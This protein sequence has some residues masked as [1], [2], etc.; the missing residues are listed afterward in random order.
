MK[1]MGIIGGLGPM[2]TAH[3]L[4]VI[5]NMTDAK[6]DQEHL[7]V[8]IFNRPQVPDRTGYILD[9][10]KPSPVVS[11]K[12]TANLLEQLGA[13]VIA[14]PCVT[15][16]YFYDELSSSVSV[17]Y[18]NMIEETAL[19]LKKCGVNKVGILAT[20]GTISTQLFQEY[21][22]KYD[23][24]V[25]IPTS[26]HQAI[27]MDIIYN[28]IKAGKPMTKQKFQKVSENLHNQGCECLVLGCTEL[29]LIDK[30][31]LENGVYLDALEV[32]AKACVLKCEAP[33]KSEYETL[34]SL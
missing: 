5:I 3:L 29:S 23:I 27:V 6:T 8:I 13:S 22:R 1:T 32:L 25:L 2:A 14:A 19:E 24:E 9:C 16:H 7:D 20:T 10:S 33:L 34:L 30:S 12:E 31:D 18:I 11:M 28:E 15:S 21:L 26:E 4:E 17:E